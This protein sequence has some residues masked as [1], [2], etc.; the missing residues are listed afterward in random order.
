MSTPKDTKITN[1][2]N[3]CYPALP[4][5]YLGALARLGMAPEAIEII[6]KSGHWGTDPDTIALLPEG[7]CRRSG[8]L[9][10][11]KQ[12]RLSEDYLIRQFYIR[13]FG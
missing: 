2:I 12:V 1:G 7:R 4:S 6:E 10:W 13:L 9:K 3:R 11:S 8:T 5:Y